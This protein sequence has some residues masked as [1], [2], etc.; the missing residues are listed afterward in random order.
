MGTLQ[1]SVNRL[2]DDMND[3]KQNGAR[4]M[5]IN[6]LQEHINKWSKYDDLKELYAKV[7][8]SIHSFEENMIIL[9]KD[10]EVYKQIVK[11]IDEVVLEKASKIS[12]D[13]L[14]D[15]L[16]CYIHID[17]YNKDKIDH[18]HYINSI[19]TEIKNIEDVVNT[20]HTN[21]NNEINITLRRGLSQLRSEFISYKTADNVVDK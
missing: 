16:H 20:I 6:E 1:H 5:H 19:K 21:M 14:Y 15:E 7:I 12:V 8:P 2:N 3:I 10:I 11:R 18:N 4:K 17:I 9:E 13:K